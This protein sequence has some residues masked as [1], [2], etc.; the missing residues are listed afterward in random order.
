MFLKMGMSVAPYRQKG[1]SFLT[2]GSDI[3]CLKQGFDYLLAAA[4]NHENTNQ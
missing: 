2:L 1:F 4:I 3:G